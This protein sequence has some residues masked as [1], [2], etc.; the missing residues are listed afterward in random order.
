MTAGRPTPRIS[1]QAQTSLLR[2]ISRRLEGTMKLQFAR[3]ARL[4]VLVGLWASGTVA[5]SQNIPASPAA[6]APSTTDVLPNR[7]PVHSPRPTDALRSM[8]PA[9]GQPEG[10]VTPQ[11]RIPLGPKPAPR[12]LEPRV[13]LPNGGTSSTPST[14]S[15]DAAARC[16]SQRGEQVRARCRDRLARES[17]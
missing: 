5:W 11:I 16:E 9:T 4:A 3:A 8:D 13:R 6:S 7:P 14:P 17:K 10:K 2:W 15:E 12:P 1:L